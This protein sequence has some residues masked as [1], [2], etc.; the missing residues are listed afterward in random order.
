MNRMSVLVLGIMACF[1][2]S[3][4]GL[5]V[6][7]Y[8]QLGQL[9]PDTDDATGEQAPPG[10]SGR[11][12][13]GRAVYAANGCVSCHTQQVRFEGVP[14]TGGP[15]IEREWGERSTVARDYL[16][17]TAAYVGSQ[18]VGPDLANIGSRKSPDSYKYTTAWHY[19]HLYQPQV[20]TPGSAMPPMR[21]L[22]EKRKIAGQR[23]HEAVKVEGEDA[24]CLHSDEEIVP[25]E[26]ARQ[27]VAYL[28]SLKRSSYPLP[29]V[30]TAPAATE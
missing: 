4:V 7:P 6:T 1:L 22:F 20:V 10:F 12:E 15:D 25:T 30:P 26:Q 14:A 17:D 9:L 19:Q 28:Q 21:F 3:W 16:R 18:R 5:A 29:E 23:S 13:Q 11:A 24:K 27:L 8:Y 2:T